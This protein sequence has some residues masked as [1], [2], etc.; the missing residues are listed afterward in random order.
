M[1]MGIGGNL[2]MWAPLAKKLNGR[3][4]I[5]FDFPGT[6]GSSMSWLP[7]TM[8]ANALFL[9]SLVHKLGHN[10]VDVLG[11]SWG[12]VLAQHLAI[13]HPSLV[14]RLI[15]ACTTF[16]WGAVPPGPKVATRMLTPHRY[17]SRPYFTKIAPELYGGRVPPRPLTGKRRGQPPRRATSRLP[18]VHRPAHS[19]R[20]LLE[21][22]RLNSYCLAYAPPGR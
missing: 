19:P 11:Y 18:R 12:G 16:G 4:L 7:P 15:L 9:R 8:A 22:A 3:T 1:V 20:Q 6:G 2:D 13:Q 17:Y 21:P 5:M 14:R 10:K